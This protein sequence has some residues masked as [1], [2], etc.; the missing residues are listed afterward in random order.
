MWNG[1]VTASG[2]QCRYADSIV[3][4][5][6]KFCKE[7]RVVLIDCSRIGGVPGMYWWRKKDLSGGQAVEQTIHQ[8]DIIRY[9]LGEAGEPVEAF[10][11]NGR[12][13]V[14]EEE[15]PG[16]DTDD[17]SADNVFSLVPLLF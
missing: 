13:F 11:Y 10:S 1:T 2:F 4:P 16:Y 8:F 14:T 6:L 15:W 9:F 3:Q 12:G 7:N 17:V 5:A